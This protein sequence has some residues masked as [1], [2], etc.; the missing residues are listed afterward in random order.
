MSYIELIDRVVKRLAR[1]FAKAD[2]WSE[3]AARAYW[4]LGGILVFAVILFLL[5]GGYLGG[6]FS[7]MPERL[8][9]YFEPIF[10]WLKVENIVKILPWSAGLIV[11]YVAA[12]MVPK[13]RNFF[14]RVLANTFY[15]V[16]D[17][18][19][20]SG[21]FCIRHRGFSMIV[22]GLLAFTI[23]WAVTGFYK[24]KGERQQLER[25][26]QTWLDET[27]RFVIEEPLF[28]EKTGR[29]A[30]LQGLWGDGYDAILRGPGGYTHTASFL[31]DAVV[32]L[33]RTPGGSEGYAKYL[34]TLKPKFEAVAVKCSHLPPRRADTP[35]DEER[36]C[37]LIN[38]LLAKI[39]TRF[40]DDEG[41]ADDLKPDYLKQSLHYYGMVP[42]S[43]YAEDDRGRRYKF[44]VNNGFGTAYNAMVTYMLEHEQTIAGAP[45]SNLD[46][47]VNKALAAYAEASKFLPLLGKE[48]KREV[49]PCS[50]QQWK[51]YNNHA[52]LLSRLGVMY[53]A[54]YHKLSKE[55]LT[56]AHMRTPREM[57]GYIEETIRKITDCNKGRGETFEFT[58]VTIAQAY[59]ACITLRG[60]SKPGAEPGAADTPGDGEL[61]TSDELARAAGL[62]LRVANSF[63]PGGAGWDLKYFCK[64]ADNDLLGA[65]LGCGLNGRALSGMPEVSLDSERGLA[66]ELIQQCSLEGSQLKENEKKL[67]RDNLKKRLQCQSQTSGK[68]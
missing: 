31:H 9:V 23:G 48:V 60:V 20:N 44:A 55:T 63:E 59:G 1:P 7:Q 38:I 66:V 64:A 35:K 61:L 49:E 21:E 68:R 27:E 56:A 43:S 22:I 47:C 34:H 33:G 12:G 2:T 54:V 52:D 50:Q 26:L 11:V 39:Y 40:A 42:A 67:L 19:I 4:R 16:T 13:L 10:E 14:G 30:R 6:L 65:E 57:Q 25:G 36:A 46:Q 17:G 53:E 8:L 32:E 29:L 5:T 37:D 28:T 24:A 51:L 3:Y 62:Y 58:A 15:R 18:L 41:I 45:C